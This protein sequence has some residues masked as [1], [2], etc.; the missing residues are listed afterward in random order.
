MNRKLGII[1]NTDFKNR[2]LQKFQKIR[3]DIL[4]QCK[5]TCEQT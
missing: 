2:E 1:I 3:E 5:S 4:S